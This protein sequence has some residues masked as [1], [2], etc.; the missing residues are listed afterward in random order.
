M[1]QQ[2][3]IGHDNS[4]EAERRRGRLRLDQRASGVR[5]G[6]DQEPGSHPSGPTFF[7]VGIRLIVA[8]RNKCPTPSQAPAGVNTRKIGSSEPT[9]PMQ[10]PSTLRLSHKCCA[11]RTPCRRRVWVSTLL[12]NGT[13]R[14]PGG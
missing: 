9:A 2:S 1:R 13:N 8:K 7:P 14:A 5:A 3:V 10:T 4:H 6:G 12:I 11:I